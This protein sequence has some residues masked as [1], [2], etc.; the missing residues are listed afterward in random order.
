MVT[1]VQEVAAPPARTAWEL[2]PVEIIDQ[3]G[4]VA[5]AG[6]DQGTA[7][8]RLIR[9]GPNEVEVHPPAPLWRSI[10]GQLRNVLVLVLL[11]AAVLTAVIG[12]FVDT[13]VILLVV[14]VNHRARC[15]P[16]APGA[17]RGP[18]PRR[19]RRPQRPG[20]QGGAGHLGTDPGARPG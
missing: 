9:D 19:P 6:L 13:A 14:T 8:A 18:V 17:A 5:A 16:G 12:D 3:E 15:R 7:A 2:S 11:A 4:V 1:D 20:D 10:V